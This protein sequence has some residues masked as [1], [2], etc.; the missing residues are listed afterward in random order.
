ME[1]RILPMEGIHNFRDYGGYLTRG[2]SRFRTGLLY[3]S[4]QHLDATPDDLATVS[5]LKLTT[6]ID[7]RGDSERMNYPCARPEDFQAEILFAPGEMADRHGNAPH[8]E[9]AESVRTA[10]QASQAMARLYKS[11]PYRPN[12]IAIFRLYFDALAKG[13]GASLIH[14]LAGKDRTGLAVGLLHKLFDVHDDD[15]Q[16]DYMLTNVAGNIDRRIAAGAIAIRRNYGEQIEDDAI[17]TL[18]SVEARYLENAFAAIIEQHGS[19]AA[20]AEEIL[21]VTKDKMEEME[22]HLLD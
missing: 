16:A 6:V 11:M 3:R 2:G 13:D 7:L 20:Y 19:I 14:C 1:D 9:A 18:M 4:G 5:D 12:L 8:V 15:I 17:R 21:H 10:E 22:A